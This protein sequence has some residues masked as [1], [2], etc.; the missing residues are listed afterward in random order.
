MAKYR[1]TSIP[2]ELPQARFGKTIKNSRLK[3]SKFKSSNKSQD[4]YD[5]ETPASPMVE[6]QGVQQPSYW[7]ESLPGY[8]RGEGCPPGSYMFNGQC[9]PESE[10]IAAFKAEM[11]KEQ[12]DFEAKSLARK[13]ALVKDINDI[14]SKANQQQE[15]YNERRNNE[16]L[17]TFAKSKKSDKIEPWKRYPET[18]VTPE[19]EAEFK[20]NF[21]VHKKDGFV[22]LFPKNIVQD[23]IITNGFQAEQFKN[24]W[25]LDPKQVKEQLGDLMG[26]AKANYEAEVTQNILKKAIEQGKPVDQVIKGLSPK[27]GTQSGLKSTFEKPTN[28]IIDDAYASLVSSMDSIPGTDRA[29]VDQDR[30]IFLESDDPMTAWEKRYHSGT[31]NLGDFINY[32]SQKT[33][34]G[35]KA[36]SD[37]MDKYGK[38]GQY[39]GLTFAKDDAMAN[40]RQNNASLNQTLNQKNALAAANT[41]KAK[42]FNDAYATYMSNLGSDATKQVLKQALDKVGSTQKGKLE[43]LKSFQ[44]NPNEA[45]QKLLQQKTGNKKETYAD[46]LNNS[47]EARLLYEKNPD[48]IKQGT[49]IN[50]NTTA[51]KVRDVLANPFDAAYFAMNPREE[52]WGNSNQS[53]ETRKDIADQ[54]GVDTG[55]MS[56]DNPLAII[57]DFTPLG[58]LNPFKVGTNLR[59]GYDKG[60]FLSGVGEELFDVGASLGLVKG[61]NAI[62]KGSK[63]YKP[64]VIKP[65]M[66]NVFNNPIS[67][68][69]YYANAPAFAESAY[70]N[71]EKGNYGTAAL[72]ALGALPAVGVAKNAFK[73]LNTLKTPGTMIANLSPESRYA[74][75]YNA[76]TPGSGIFMGNPTTAIPG[77]GQPK[78]QSITRPINTLSKGLGFGEFNINKVNP[79][80]RVPQ[81]PINTNLLGYADG[82]L[83]KARTGVIV[84]G[85]QA[86]GTS[87][88]NAARMANIG[89]IGTVN[90]LA[91][92]IAPVMI[93]PVRIPLFGTS[94]EKMGPFTG[95]PLNALPFYGEKMNPVDG[96]AF[97]KFG[98]TLDYVKISKELNPAAGPL[99][100]MGKNQIMSEGNWAELNEPNEQYSG[101]FGAQFNRN[102]PG[103]DLS[104][105]KMSNRNG[106]LVTDALGNRKPSIPLSEPGLSF[107]RRLPFSN[108]YIPV[109]MDKLRNDEFDWRT[110]GGNLQSLIERYG[111]GAAYAAALAGMGMAAPQEYLDEYITEPVKKVYGKAEELLTNPWVK[112]KN[113]KGGVVSNLSKKEIDQYIKDGYIIEDV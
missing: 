40:V 74:F 23:R 104:F 32:Q 44:E 50:E 90:S 68:L 6:V 94:I 17:E 30:K 71:F 100:R 75:T 35:E 101:V 91:K 111:Y 108:K 1:I 49:G 55:L 83:V 15:A 56:N 3:K 28:K 70:D 59:K 54:F 52:M 106:V 113:K 87:G 72:D 27:I 61:L 73:T 109:N 20:N 110:Q 95:S 67:Q 26:A 25:G 34:R 12:E 76:A 2:Q 37:W 11:Q 85:L 57:R 13:L 102:V 79:G 112:P 33:E 29:K 97:R 8:M 18:D 96:T 93:N 14:R 16:Y 77:I 65:L 81:Q 86:L 63:W 89:T 51:S 92:N 69:S 80:W 21:L 5:G 38:A 107:H 66:S 105:E 46:I 98:D 36:Y 22:E 43:I 53:Y 82:G 64:N 9:L 103:S 10:Y 42:D 39:D 60:E 45:M 84:K 99:L 62:T 4:P 24:Y 58:A 47:L 19:I 48:T 41:A 88:K 31:N 78:F 7:N